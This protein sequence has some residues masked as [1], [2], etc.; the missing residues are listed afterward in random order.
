[1]LCINDV[2]T[3]RKFD[4]LAEIVG[5]KEAWRDFFEQQGVVRPPRI[6]LEKIKQ[7][8][9]TEPEEM[10]FDAEDFL[11]DDVIEEPTNIIND[12]NKT[13]A[14]GVATKLSEALSVPFEVISQEQAFKLTNRTGTKGFFLQGKV[15]FVEGMFDATTAFHE[16]AH[17]VIKTLVNDNFAL[18]EKLYSEVE[19]SLINDVLSKYPDLKNDKKRLIEEVLVTKMTTLNDQ[20][21]TTPDTWGSRL[22]Y[23]IKKLLRAI[24]DKGIKIEKLKHSTTLEE[25]VKM[26]NSGET[27][28][29]NNSFLNQQL[30]AEFQLD[31]DAVANEIRTVG[32]Q[33]AQVIIDNYYNLIKNQLSSFTKENDVW[34]TISEELSDEENKGI[35]QQIKLF[36]EEIATPGKATVT[37]ENETDAVLEAKKIRTFIESISMMNV[38]FDKFNDR[39]AELEAGGMTDVRDFDSLFALEKYVSEWHRFLFQNTD[40]LSYVMEVNTNH[41]LNSL[42]TEIRGKLDPNVKGTLLSRIHELKEESVLDKVVGFIQEYLTPAI[43]EINEQM[44]KALANN[45]YSNYN[46]L[47]QHLYGLTTD[48]MIDLTQLQSDQATRTLSLDEKQK[49]EELKF[50]SYSGLIVSKDALRERLKGNLGSVSWYNDM[51]ITRMQ[52]QDPSVGAFYSFITDTLADVNGTVNSK[53]NKFQAGLKPLLEKANVDNYVFGEEGLGQKITQEE[54]IYY[55][56]EPFKERAY[57]NAFINWQVPLAELN[58]AVADAKAEYNNNPTDENKLKLN[59]AEYAA[60]KFNIDYMNMDFVDEVYEAELVLGGFEDTDTVGIE[61]RT[62]L[63]DIYDRIN[64]L[65]DNAAEAQAVGDYSLNDDINELYKELA[66]MHEVFVKGVKKTGLDLEVALRLQEY[67]KAKQDFYEWNIDNIKFDNAYISYQKY[68]IDIK[69][70]AK[71]TDEFTA[72]LEEWLEHNTVVELTEEYNERRAFLLAERA[73]ILKPFSDANKQLADTTELYEQLYSILRRQTDLFGQYDGTLLTEDE[74][75]QVKLLHEQIEEANKLV[76]NRKGMNAEEARRFDDYYKQGVYNLTGSD[77]EDWKK[78]QEKYNNGLKQFGISE[79]DIILLHDIENQLHANTHTSLTHHYRSEFLSFLSI[80]E[81]YDVLDEYFKPLGI[82]LATDDL[83]DYHYNDILENEQLVAKLL[84]AD[85][86]FKD[87]FLRNHYATQKLKKDGKGNVLGL[88]PIWK[89]TAAWNYTTPIDTKMFKSY[90]NMDE[91]GKLTTTVGGVKKSLG[92]IN[93]NGIPRVPSIKYRSRKVKEEYTREKI[94]RDFVEPTT[95]EL[96]VANVDNKG[97]WLPKTPQMGAKDNKYINNDYFNMFNSDPDLWNVLDYIKNFKLDNQ[98]GLDNSQKSYLTVP[99]VRKGTLGFWSGGFTSIARRIWNRIADTFRH[100]SDDAELGII[101][102]DN[103]FKDAYV[104]LEHPI[105]GMYKVDVNDVSLNILFTEKEQLHS[106]ELFKALRK[107]NAFA[108]SYTEVAKMLASGERNPTYNKLINYRRYIKGKSQ[109]ETLE[110]IYDKLYKGESLLNKGDVRVPLQKLQQKFTNQSSF[111]YFWLNYISSA[112]NYLSGKLQMLIKSVDKNYFTYG[113]YVIGR[114]K[115]ASVMMETISQNYKKDEFSTQLQLLNVMDAVPDNTKRSLSKRGTKTLAQNIVGLDFGYADRKFL[116]NS[117]AVHAFY[118]LL[119]NHKVDHNGKKVPLYDLVELRDKIIHTKSGVPTEW[120]INY[121]AEGNIVLGKEIK[122][123]MKMHQNALLKLTGVANEYNTPEMYRH[124]FWRFTFSMMRFLPTMILDKWGV[125]VQ[126][127]KLKGRV[128]WATGKEEK[129]TFVDTLELLYKVA[130]LNPKRITRDNY[131]GL[132]Q[133]SI[134]ISISYLLRVLSGSWRFNDGDDDQE[135]L[136]F[137][138]NAEGM[139]SDL[140]HTTRLPGVPLISENNTDKFVGRFDPADWLDLQLLRL[141]LRVERE[142]NTFYPSNLVEP[143]ANLA[144][145]KTPAQEGTLTHLRDIIK[146]MSENNDKKLRYTKE[147]GP[148]SWQ[149][150]GDL[151]W[152]NSI[153]KMFGFSGKFWDPA[154]AIQREQ[155]PLK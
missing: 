137:N 90:V 13:Q 10:L 26:I 74:Q 33:K 1:M 125:K 70:Y 120:M 75:E 83:H 131:I 139:Y 14:L 143:I 85:D 49:L 121:D 127:G 134:G 18:A 111:A 62:R 93:I 150:K 4:A 20:E 102:P 52:S 35:L 141:N 146:L 22:Y 66:Q 91:E 30:L 106:I 89:R 8:Q 100:A 147:A 80:S 122:R 40:S 112:T 107:T 31:Y 88:F 153:G 103:S 39:L 144:T 104:S 79:A 86:S 105:T 38:V 6:V 109:Y 129:G 59:K 92:V 45:D 140:K 5:E 24:F 2:E 41:P 113:D 126:K 47:H 60:L 54:T 12:F 73:R 124:A 19:E 27:I 95:G 11:S 145:F 135:E 44:N 71:G 142:A 78:L 25:L 98:K 132:M 151:K 34:V 7:R 63:K 110:N 65:K 149:E 138:K 57:M 119:H 50:K 94:E 72:A 155:N 76:Y 43:D 9:E 108:N 116:Q 69:G 118:A 61:A 51:F 130:T 133:V 3:Q 29:L 16:F 101:K 154:L 152:P 42:I 37:L 77:L 15:Y 96:I 48:E 123:L 56:G 87:W 46:K 55:K 84:S 58:K 36:L 23:A 21:T 68:L 64:I 148:Y 114:A 32:K 97:R 17:P 53:I 28:F 67:R 115:A 81:V 99:S 117:V 136:L 82:D 128:N